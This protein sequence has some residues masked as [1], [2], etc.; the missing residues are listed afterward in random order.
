MGIAGG[1][2][3]RCWGVMFTDVEYTSMRARGHMPVAGARG[4][5]ECL[6]TAGL[7]GRVTATGSPVRHRLGLGSR[8]IYYG[9]LIDETHWL[10]ITVMTKLWEVSDE[11]STEAA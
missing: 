1:T 3:G 7:T 9:R 4:V 6:D 8:L 2:T 10:P 11:T 5:D